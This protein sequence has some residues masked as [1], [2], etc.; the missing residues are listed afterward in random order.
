MGRG[1]I[2]MPYNNLHKK[3]QTIVNWEYGTIA[4]GGCTAG[5]RMVHQDHDD[6]NASDFQT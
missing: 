1:H 6:E 4:T 5:I 2:T 3:I